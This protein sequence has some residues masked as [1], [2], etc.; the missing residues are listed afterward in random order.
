MPAYVISQPGQSGEEVVIEDQQLTVDF[1]SG[2]ALFS[3]D[4]G[5]C[6]ALPDDL[7]ATIQRVDNPPT[8]LGQTSP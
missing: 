6:F 3:D 8:E 2:W 5:L 1:Q 4:N 7:G